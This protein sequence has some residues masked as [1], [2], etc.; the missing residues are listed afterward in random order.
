MHAR[1]AATGHYSLFVCLF[2]CLFIMKIVHIVHSHQADYCR[3]LKSAI[4]SD[5]EGLCTSILVYRWSTVTYISNMH[6]DLQAE[7]SEWLSS[8][9]LQGQ[10]HIVAATLQ[11][12]EFV[13]FC[14]V[15]QGE[16]NN[17]FD[18]LYQNM[19][20]GLDASKEFSDFLRERYVFL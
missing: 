14:V 17:G 7:S 16:K 6:G 13:G 19:K 12:A 20:Y 4:S 1:C 15:A 2:V 8:H 18:V 10:G 5:R 9:H 3:Y 11:A